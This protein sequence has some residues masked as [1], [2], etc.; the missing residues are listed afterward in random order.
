M[1]LFGNAALASGENVPATT[2]EAPVGPAPGILH[3]ASFPDLIALKL[4]SDRSYGALPLGWR[5]A[6][7]GASV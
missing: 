4:A 5:G 6:V 3:N 1:R 2:S 7:E